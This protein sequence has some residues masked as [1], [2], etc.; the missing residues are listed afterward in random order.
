MMLALD[1]SMR[2]LSVAIGDGEREIFMSSGEMVKQAAALPIAVSSLLETTGRTLAD[3]SSIACTVGP[4]YYT[5]IRVGLSYASS[6]AE[7]LGIGLIA[8][9]PLRLLCLSCEKFFRGSTIA[10][11]LRARTGAFYAAAWRCGERVVDDAYMSEA[12]LAS[13]V[14]DSDAVAACASERERS[15]ALELG[16]TAYDV[17]D[18]AASS[19]I[20]AANERE[21]VD[22]T[23]VRAVYLRDP[24]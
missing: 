23:E 22:P 15:A 9:S 19:L 5:G 7:A 6:L 16:L 12:D 10:A 3:V 1:C 13:I 18:L 20:E 21:P 17:G 2:R 24:D 8:I 14:R 4:G 11:V